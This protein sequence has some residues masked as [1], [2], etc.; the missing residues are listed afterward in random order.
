VIAYSEVIAYNIEWSLNCRFKGTDILPGACPLYSPLLPW[1]HTFFQDP[2]DSVGFDGFIWVRLIHSDLADA[3]GF[4]RFVFTANF[5]EAA[6]EKID[7][8][9][10]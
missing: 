5:R 2:A 9:T 10:I 7:K 4:G 6:D 8:K 1:I 3:F